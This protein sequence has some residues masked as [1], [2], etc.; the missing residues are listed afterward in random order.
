VV[1]FRMTS[2][3]EI[4]EV[5][6]EASQEEIKTAYRRLA[7]QFHPDKN[8]GNQTAEEKFKEISEAYRILADTER[9]QLYDL[10]GDAGLAGLDLEDFNGFKDIFNSFGEAFEDFFNFGRPQES[11]EGQPQP[12]AD[13][14]QPVV[15]TLE[16][17]AGGLS[18]SLTVERR[19]SCSHCQGSGEEPGSERQVCPRCQGSGQVSQ[20]KGL[21][22]ALHVCPNCQGA[23]F[24]IDTPCSNCQGSGVIKEKKEIQVRIPPGVD[25]G[26]R[27]RLRGEGEAG[28][29]GAPP[30][31]LYLEIHVTPHPTFTRKGKDLYYR[32]QLSF[33]QAALGTEV[34][35]PTLTSQTRLHIL[36]GTQPGATFRIPHLGLPGLRGK[37]PGDLVVV[38]DLHTPTQ[39][40]EHQ[41]AL[42]QE[43]LRLEDDG[44]LNGAKGIHA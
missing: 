8:P 23:G 18:T 20:A 4:L 40:S 28:T 16:E 39:L 3:Y 1:V 25:T 14:R 7:L 15:M 27:L 30:G 32:T 26:T 13:L 43:F 44:E 11:Q 42:L 41:R 29:R 38:A 31:D 2:Y 12:G 34:E 10:Y 21:L 36:P 6:R 24:V 37:P 17:V 35:V 19:G 5:S 33:A 22:K 9:R